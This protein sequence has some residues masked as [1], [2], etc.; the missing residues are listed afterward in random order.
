MVD[1][2]SINEVEW[3]GEGSMKPLRNYALHLL[4]LIVTIAWIYP[5]I[6]TI[7]S[8]LKSNQ[9]FFDGSINPL[10]SDFRWEMLLPTHWGELAKVFHFE[11]YS[12]AW[13]LGKFHVYF[14]NTILF[15]GLVVLIVVLLCGLTGYALARY[16]FPGKMAFLAATTATTLIPQG[17]IRS[18]SIML[19]IMTLP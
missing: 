6:W 15:S 10:P 5:I 12:H 17:Y 3:K 13:D 8:S 2:V 7:S 19:A 16:R 4:F 18:F 14:I 9:E 1:E 11:N